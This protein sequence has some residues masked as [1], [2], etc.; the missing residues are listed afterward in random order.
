MKPTR[1]LRTHTYK[2]AMRCHVLSALAMVMVMVMVQQG[3]HAATTIA[4]YPG[5]SGAFSVPEPS[6]VPC[7]SR[8]DCCAQARSCL[9]HLVYNGTLSGP[10]GSCSYPSCPNGFCRV[11]GTEPSCLRQVPYANFVDTDFSYTSFDNCWNKATHVE[12]SLT[13]NRNCLA[14]YMT[15]HEMCLQYSIDICFT[16]TSF[17]ADE[18]DWCAYYQ[19][20]NF[21]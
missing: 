7:I 5:G 12:P 2:M 16:Q 10:D 17:S 18:T 9:R 8:E 19:F 1:N 13:R 3:A 21:P 11:S 4:G 6:S 15:A 14:P 20:T